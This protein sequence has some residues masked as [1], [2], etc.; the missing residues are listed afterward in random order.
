MMC[1]VN[2]KALSLACVTKQTTVPSGGNIDKNPQTGELTGILRD[3]ATN[4]VWRVVPEPT[5]DE[6]S[7]A[8]VLA[9]QEIVKAG[10]TSVH[11]IILSENELTLIQRLTFARKASCQG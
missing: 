4:L 7:E 10:L 9:C 2:D 1:V 5:V 6:L 3:S 8:T 11:W